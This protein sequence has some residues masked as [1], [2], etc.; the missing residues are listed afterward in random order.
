MVASAAAE[1][2]RTNAAVTLRKKPGEKQAAVAQL[3]P[4]TPVVI[5]SEAGRWLRVR[6]GSTVGYLTRTQ[7]TLPPAA[8]ASSGEW[9]ANEPIEAGNSPE[10]PPGDRYHEWRAGMAR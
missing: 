6:V 10:R 2:P 3:K 5:E 7:L 9:A 8:P 4:G 1:S